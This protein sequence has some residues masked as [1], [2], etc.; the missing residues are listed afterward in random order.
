MPDLTIQVLPIAKLHPNPWN[1]NVQTAAVQ[2]AERQS[3][4]VFGFIDPVTVRRHPD[5]PGEWEIVDGEHRWRDLVS[6][7][8]SQI[9]AIEL[10]LDDAAARKLTIVLNETRGDADVAMLGM[11]LVELEALMPAEDLGIALPY[12][13][14]ELEHLLSLGR[15]NWDDFQGVVARQSE[16]EDGHTL[17]LKFSDE[18]MSEV[19]TWLG[20]IERELELDRSGAAAEAFRRLAVELH[21]AGVPEP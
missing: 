9:E 5:L 10:E 21:G 20:I 17:A 7:G 14:S 4:D 15:E 11:L 1:P 19:A 2:E 16:E 18:M 13:P 3:I 12:T 8:E 6:R